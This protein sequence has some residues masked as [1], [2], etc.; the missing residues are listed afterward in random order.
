MIYYINKLFL[1]KTFGF[2]WVNIKKYQINGVL[3]K[4]CQINV[5]NFYFIKKNAHDRIKRIEFQK[6][7]LNLD[8]EIT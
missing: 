5:L 2:K 3:M 6:S 1:T 8:L 4:K 7:S